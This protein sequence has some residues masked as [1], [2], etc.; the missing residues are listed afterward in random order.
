M[1]TWLEIGT[2]FGFIMGL[3][4]DQY[5]SDGKNLLFSY[6]NELHTIH[7]DTRKSSLLVGNNS[8]KITYREGTGPNALFN[9]MRAFS[10]ISRDTILIADSLNKL[11]RA[12]SRGKNSTIL[13]VGTLSCDNKVDGHFSVACFQGHLIDLAVLSKDIIYVSE[14]H[15]IRKVD[16]LNGRVQTV[17]KH[18]SATLRVDKRNSILYYVDQHLFAY[19]LDS[20]KSSYMTTGQNTSSDGKFSDVKFSFTSK[21]AQLQNSSTLLLVDRDNYRIR[22]LDLTTKMVSSICTYDRSHLP[23]GV[24]FA[25][26]D[27]RHCYLEHM[28]S[29]HMWNATTIFVGTSQNITILTSKYLP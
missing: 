29:V 4:T 28:Y 23:K 11:L 12:V 22:V 25:V 5:A 18:S 3:E 20:K 21:M 7:V 2:E 15:F 6:H 27:I 14:L 17:G 16:L 19:S 26:G 1:D 9:H 24:Y 13:I 10:Q 8:N